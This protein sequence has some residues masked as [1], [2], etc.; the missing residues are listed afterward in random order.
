[1]PGM[2]VLCFI[3]RMLHLN[4]L[5]KDLVVFSYFVLRLLNQL[6][7]IVTCMNGKEGSKNGRSCPIFRPQF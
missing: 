1:M 6:M 4:L 3:L 5:I 2:I 7:K